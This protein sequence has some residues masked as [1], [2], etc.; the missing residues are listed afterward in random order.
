MIDTSS[1]SQEDW[2]VVE[3]LAAVTKR[4]GKVYPWFRTLATATSLPVPVVQQ[5]IKNLVVAGLLIPEDGYWGVVELLYSLA[6]RSTR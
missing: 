1:L 5:S 2:A 6:E 4:T 3:Y